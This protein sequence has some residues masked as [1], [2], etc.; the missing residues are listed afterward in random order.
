MLD[1]GGVRLLLVS[2]PSSEEEMDRAGGAVGHGAAVP[3]G[4]RGGTGRLEGHRGRSPPRGVQAER[5]QLDRSLRAGRTGLPRRSLPPP[6]DLSPPDASRHRGP[7]LR[8]AKEASRVG[9]SPHRA[10]TGQGRREPGSFAILHLPL[11][12][13]S[14]PGGAQASPEAP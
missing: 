12:E 5:P 10:P 8:D 1:S 7:D 11:P 2:A 14:R 13:A 3:S 9:T 6:R 4:A